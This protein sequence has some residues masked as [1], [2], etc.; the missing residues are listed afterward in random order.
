MLRLAEGFARP[1]ETLHDYV[2]TPELKACYDDAISFIKSDLQSTTSKA[3]YGHA[4]F[5]SGKSPFMEVLPL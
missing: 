5:G 4:S 1:E 3:S 2:V